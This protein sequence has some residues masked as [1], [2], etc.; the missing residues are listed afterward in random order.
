MQQPPLPFNLKEVF[1]LGNL[2]LSPDLFKFGGV[3][4]E[5]QKYICI[6]DAKVSYLFYL[7]YSRG[8]Q[9]F[10]SFLI[11]LRHH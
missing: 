7:G 4:F 5:S 8:A 6:K 2:G 9:F 3:T 11:G 1:K 10:I